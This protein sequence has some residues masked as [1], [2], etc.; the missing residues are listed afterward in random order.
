MVNLSDFFSTTPTLKECVNGLRSLLEWTKN[1]K[2]HQD[3]LF[4]SAESGVMICRQLRF[5]GT[6]PVTAKTNLR[7]LQIVTSL[8]NKH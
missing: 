2:K 5:E 6:T 8:Y 1:S 7:R 3:H 4:L